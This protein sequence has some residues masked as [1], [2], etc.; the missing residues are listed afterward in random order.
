MI[1]ERMSDDHQV[2]QGR[3]TTRGSWGLSE[4][5][6][7]LA[8]AVLLMW[9]L[10]RWLTSGVYYD[11]HLALV[12]SYAVVWVPLLGASVIACARGGK[13]SLGR[14]LGLQ[15]RWLDI[16]FGF[17][18]G[19]LARA[20]ASIVEIAF[21]GRMSGLGVTLGDVIY[22]GWWVFGFLFAPVVFAPFV[23]ELFFRGLV[24]RTAL[25]LCKRVLPAW[26]AIA[27]SVIVSASLFSL[28]HLAEVT[29]TTAAAVLGI[30]TLVFGIGSGTL[31]ALTGR[32]GGSIAAHVTF[33]SSLIL[34]TLLA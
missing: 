17:S 32:I 2:P 7:G 18:I 12:L 4:S 20:V 31:A 10:V 34:A 13:G 21:Y 11:G 26:G 28:L 9:L 8:S 23:E 30:S 6:M 27:V 3:I 15:F 24:Q 14:D 29:N 16:L 22:D 33:N 19:I 5:I 25:G 1:G